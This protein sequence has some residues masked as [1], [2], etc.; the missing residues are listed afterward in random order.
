M[1]EKGENNYKLC[2]YSTNSGFVCDINIEYTNVNSFFQMEDGN[3]IINGCG[4]RIV[5]IKKNSIEQIF[6]YNKQLSI[7]K[8]LLNDNFLIKR[9]EYKNGKEPINI[10]EYLAF[11]KKIM[12]LYT[13]DK[14]ELK[15]YKNI[16]EFYEKDKYCDICQ[17]NKNEYVIY[18]DQKGIIYGINDALIFYDM[19]T[20]QNIKILKVG[21]GSNNHEMVLA[22]E[23]NLIIG[24]NDSIILVDAKNR[25]IK[26]EFKYNISPNELIF[27]NKKI[28]LRQD[29][30]RITQYEFE[31]SNTIKDKGKREIKNQAILKYPGN[32]IVIKRKNIITILGWYKIKIIN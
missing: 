31:D 1:D 28:F 26:N 6:K 19:Y 15:F 13:Y 29:Y 23:N 20:N 3:V 27:L 18:T 7:N 11:T 24:G 14:G 25:K 9:E 32:K 10:W 12:E 16:N 21:K 4:I 17:I 22:D 5:K 2:V 8:R 30:Y